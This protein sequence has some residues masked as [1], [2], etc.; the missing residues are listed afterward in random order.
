MGALDP[1]RFGGRVRL[2]RGLGAPE[3]YGHT[4]RG[5]ELIPSFIMPGPGGR[6]VEIPH[7]AAEAIGGRS[8]ARETI[9]RQAESAERMAL[10]DELIRQMREAREVG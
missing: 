3:L 6:T 8:A 10:I 5:R 1:E 4:L 2:G 7:L 9:A